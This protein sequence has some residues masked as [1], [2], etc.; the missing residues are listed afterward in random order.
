[1]TDYEKFLITW[2]F[3]QEQVDKI[4]HNENDRINVICIWDLVKLN[5]SDIQGNGLFAKMSLNIGMNVGPARILHYRTQLGRYLNHDKNPNCKFVKTS[6]GLDTIIIRDIKCNE[7]L[8][9]SY[10]QVGEVNGYIEQ[11]SILD[12]KNE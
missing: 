11:Q 9:V 3:T 8:T 12:A 2:N 10:W 1:M 7:E 5:K 4:V 6:T